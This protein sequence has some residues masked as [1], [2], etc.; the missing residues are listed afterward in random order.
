[1]WFLYVLGLSTMLLF[2]QDYTSYTTAYENDI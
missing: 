1:M 2:E